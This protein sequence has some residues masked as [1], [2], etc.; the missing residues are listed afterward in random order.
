M[1]P[2]ARFEAKLDRRDDGCWIWKASCYR[3]GYGQFYYEG[4]LQ[5]AHRVSWQLYRGPIPESLTIDHLCRTKLCMNPEHLE[6]VTMRVNSQRGKG[7]TTVCAQGHVYDK[8]NTG[9]KLD[10]KRGWRRYCRMCAIIGGRRRRGWP[11]ERLNDA[12]I[13]QRTSR[14]KPP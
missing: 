4:R 9:W 1:D 3:N 5:P 14:L 6:P 13:Y 2:L 12:L 10:G 11:A 8:E 7:S